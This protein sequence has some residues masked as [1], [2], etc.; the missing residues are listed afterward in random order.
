[1]VKFS[2]LPQTH[3]L[4]YRKFNS[5]SEADKIMAIM[6]NELDEMKSTNKIKLIEGQRILILGQ[7]INSSN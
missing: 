1:M 7:E 3:A 6:K 5:K 4:W 2:E